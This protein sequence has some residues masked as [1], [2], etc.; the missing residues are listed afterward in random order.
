[1]AQSF[2]QFKPFDSWPECVYFFQQTELISKKIKPTQTLS[3]AQG[4]LYG[5]RKAHG[6]RTLL[7]AF[8]RN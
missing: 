5:D 8:A 1:M 3:A 7:P 2:I 6:I 4:L